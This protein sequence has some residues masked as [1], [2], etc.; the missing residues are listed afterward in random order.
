MIRLRTKWGAVIAAGAVGAALSLSLASPLP[1]LADE[2]AEADA[3]AS[4]DHGVAVVVADSRGGPNALSSAEPPDNDAVARTEV[5]DP[6]DPVIGNVADPRDPVIGNVADPR[7]PVVEVEND[8]PVVQ[9]EPE[10]VG[11]DGPVDGPQGAGETEGGLEGAEAPS[12]NEPVDS[13]TDATVDGSDLDDGADDAEAGDL[14]SEDVDLT[15]AGDEADPDEEGA[16]ELDDS[17]GS[18]RVRPVD[19]WYVDEETGEK[20]WYEDGEMVRGK[21]IWDPE[22]DAWYWI[23]ADG[24]LAVNKDVYL[25]NGDKWVRYDANGHMIKGEDYRVSDVD[26][27]YH[28]WYFDLKTGA[29]MKRFVQ[30]VGQDKVCYYDE[31]FGWMVYGER[32]VQG[33]DGNYHW[34]YFD[35]HTGAMTHGWK[36]I[37]SGNKWVYYDDSG[38]MLYGQHY[39]SDGSDNPEK[40]WYYF[41][42]ATGATQYGYKHI[43][44]QGK[45][46]YYQPGTGWMLYGWQNINGIMN[47]FDLNTGAQCASTNAAYA[48]WQRVQNMSSSSNYF[49]VIDNTNCR[50]VV[51]TGSQGNWTPY[52]DWSC[53]VGRLPIPGGD[54]TYGITARGVY[55]ITR[56]GYIMGQCPYEFYWSEFFLGND[57]SGEGQRFHSILYWDQNHTSVYEDGRGTASTHGCVRLSLEQAKWIYDVVPIGTT[58][59]SYA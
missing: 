16:E 45:T 6:R 39:L 31:V 5:A 20:Y 22:T 51:F 2:L 11:G 29:M 32:Y 46:V 48:A 34:Y 59:Y 19:G 53:A 21:E 23:D 28:W 10:G 9:E 42:E 57:P 18:D 35:D 24:T 50:V 14:E 3:L 8:A 4:S 13:Q 25:A 54:Q 36:Y 7:D 40:H 44:S 38:E 30:V 58:V 49:L 26:D 1:A 15:T 43:E 27:A 17:E 33:D 47:Y 41:D 12:D 52:A 56:K 55:T 37:D